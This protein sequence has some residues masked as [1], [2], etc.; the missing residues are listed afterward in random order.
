MKRMSFSLVMMIMLTLNLL[1]WVAM[2]PE[3]AAT[4]IRSKKWRPQETTVIPLTTTTTTEMPL[5]MKFHSHQHPN[6]RC[7]WPCKRLKLVGCFNGRCYY[8]CNRV[9]INGRKMWEGMYQSNNCLL[10]IK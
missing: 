10:I 5:H 9:C 2:S 3:P 4:A 1:N 8:R 6:V 7:E